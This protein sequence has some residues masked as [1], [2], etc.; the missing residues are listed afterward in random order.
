MFQGFPGAQ[1][2]DLA[3][4]RLLARKDGLKAAGLG[5]GAGANAPA[6][7]RR[8][9]PR[10]K[11][12]RLAG[13]GGAA[14]QAAPGRV[15]CRRCAARAWPAAGEGRWSIDTAEASFWPTA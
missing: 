11:P 5:F 7:I 14:G 9:G 13:S 10:A 1:R 6:A 15:V 12:R 4:R 3:A 2:H 8:N